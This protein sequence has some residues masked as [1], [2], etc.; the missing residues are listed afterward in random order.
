MKEADLIVTDYTL[1]IWQLVIIGIII[2]VLVFV[3]KLY[4][5]ITK[6]LNLKTSYLKEKMNLDE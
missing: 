1:L 6:Y 2:T 4:K 5:K 3:C